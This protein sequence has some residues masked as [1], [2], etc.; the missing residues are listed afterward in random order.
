MIEWILHRPPHAS[1]PAEI[2][3]AE[4]LRGL[5]DSP[6]AWTVIWGYYYQDSRGMQ[7]E[8]DFLILGPAGGLLVLEV[9]SSL[10]RHFPETGRWEG[11]GGDDPFS[12][13]NTEWQG[14]IRHC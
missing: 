8:G 11:A 13:L 7:R 5:A 2:R 9:K 4:R 3:V 12:Q 6:H 1:N 14:V 10:P